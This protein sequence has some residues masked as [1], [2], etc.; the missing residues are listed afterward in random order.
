MVGMLDSLRPDRRQNR[1]PVWFLAD[2]LLALMFVWITVESLRSD[3]YV[4][5]YGSVEGWWLLLAISP[6]LL[7]PLRR[8][9]P[10]VTLAVATGLYMVISAFQGDSN[11]P[12]AVPFFAYSVG[13]T[14]PP[15]VSGAMVGGAAVL[16]STS[17]FYGPGDPV[18]L[19]V[20]VTLML[21]GIGWLVAVSIRRNQATARDMTARAVEIEATSAQVTEQAI[22]DERSR[23]ARELHDAVGHAV[24]VIVVHAGA[25]R[26]ATTDD[27]TA[28]TLREIE[29]VGRSALGDLDQMLG[30]LDTD[31]AAEAAP[32]QPTPGLGDIPRLVDDMR[33]VGADVHLH[34]PGGALTAGGI[35]RPVNAAAYRIA[36]EA[37][38]NA[39]KHAGDARIDVTVILRDDE[40]LVTVEDDGRGLSSMGSSGGRGIPGMTERAARLG[41]TLTATQGPA[42]GF[43]V[44][45]TLPLSLDRQNVHAPQIE[46][47]P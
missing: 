45:A 33:A 37:L 38:T 28:E 36:Q 6:T 2:A 23:I 11:A 25:A 27:R 40:L 46:G 32:L 14:R 16:M 13:L 9:A 31:P 3:A 22:R 43:R 18:V 10:A 35:E 30:L 24:N 26:L 39:L 44:Y 47:S 29:R 7:I 5:D 42:G 4:N 41:G 21:F 34:D 17:V 15:R 19:S 12:L 1:Q 8:L 20:P